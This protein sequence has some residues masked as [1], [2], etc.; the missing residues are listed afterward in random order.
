M[1]LA[2]LADIHGNLPALQTVQAHIERWQPDAVIVAGDIVNRG[3]RSPEC[4]RVIQQM[5]QTASWQ[6]VRGNHEDYVINYATGDAPVIGPEFEIFRLA[7]YTYNQLGENVAPLQAMPFS[8]S[9]PGPDNREIRVVHASMVSNRSGIF[10]STPDRELRNRLVVP[11]PALF[12][13]GHTHIPL[14]RR[15]D[16]T[17]VVNVGSVGLP[18]DGDRRAAYGQLTWHNGR[19]SAD[20]IRLDYDR[21]QA[22]RDFFETDYFPGTGPMGLLVLDEFRSARSRMYQ[23]MVSYRDPTLAGRISLDDAVDRFL[24]ET[25]GYLLT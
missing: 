10:H 20:I 21:R 19:W 11:P 2:V 13:V 17:L 16:D 15:F 8:I 3:P 24:V 14:V 18:F 4:L 23:W 12:C 1:K 7:F 6:V 5:E 25:H 22:E 9:I